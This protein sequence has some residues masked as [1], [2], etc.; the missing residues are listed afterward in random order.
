MAEAD[1]ADDQRKPWVIPV[2]FGILVA[3]V[4]LILSTMK[5][6]KT[7]GAGTVPGEDGPPANEQGLTGTAQVPEAVSSTVR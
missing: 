3:L 7:A 6:P 1:M 2:F 5:P 4:W